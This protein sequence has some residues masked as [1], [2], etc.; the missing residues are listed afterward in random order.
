MGVSDRSVAQEQQQNE[1]L[2]LSRGTNCSVRLIA[3]SDIA[4]VAQAYVL[5]SEENAPRLYI[6]EY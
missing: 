3:R 2:K 1:L 4:L 6:S 5:S